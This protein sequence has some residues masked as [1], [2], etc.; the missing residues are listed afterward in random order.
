MVQKLVIKPNFAQI[1]D[2]SVNKNFQEL[3]KL[4]ALFYQGAVAVQVTAVLAAGDN[5]ITPTVAS[6]QGRFIVYQDAASTLFDKGLNS[7]GKW[8]IN[9]SAPCTVRLAFF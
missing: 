5:E 4:F 6:P 1:K 9:A 2:D 8:V 3:V 7:S